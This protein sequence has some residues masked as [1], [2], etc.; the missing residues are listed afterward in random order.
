MQKVSKNLTN[1]RPNRHKENW[2][3]QHSGAPRTTPSATCDLSIATACVFLLWSIFI[4]KR[5]HQVDLRF[6]IQNNS[7]PARHHRLATRFQSVSNVLSVRALI[8]LLILWLLAGAAAVGVKPFF[9]SQC[10]RLGHDHCQ[11]PLAASISAARLDAANR[12]SVQQL[13]LRNRPLASWALWRGPPTVSQLST[14][15]A[16]AALPTPTT[17]K[18]QH[19]QLCD[20]LCHVLV[21]VYVCVFDILIFCSLL[22]VCVVS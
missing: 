18:Q 1:L 6:T 10:D 19:R 9:M 4:S 7:R 2:V 22:V 5:L 14:A 20:R 21:C 15:A 3:T 16:P 12:T 8:C 11:T 17:T 13:P